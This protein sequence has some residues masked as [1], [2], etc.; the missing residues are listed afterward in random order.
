[1]AFIEWTTWANFSTFAL[2]SD[3]MNGC[4]SNRQQNEVGKIPTLPS[5]DLPLVHDSSMVSKPKIKIQFL[6]QIRIN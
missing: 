4:E 3:R 2:L 6:I 1:M 5:G